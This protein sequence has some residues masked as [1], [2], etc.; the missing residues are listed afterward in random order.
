MLLRYQNMPLFGRWTSVKIDVNKSRH[1]QQCALFCRKANRK[2]LEH[3][4]S[5]EA[6]PR[7]SRVPLL[8]ECN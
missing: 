3:E 1:I 7:R 5:V 6:N 2:Q 4:R 8:L